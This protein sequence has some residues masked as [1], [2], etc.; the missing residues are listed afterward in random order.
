MWLA[1]DART[2]KLQNGQFRTTR[3]VVLLGSV[4]V[5]HRGRQG[6]LER[7]IAAVIAMDADETGVSQRGMCRVGRDNANSFFSLAA[8]VY[9]GTSASIGMAGA[10]NGNQ[11]R[12]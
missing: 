8:Y 7:R 10:T 6:F 1:L 4:G 3:L 9:K 2:G 12:S 5:G 11:G